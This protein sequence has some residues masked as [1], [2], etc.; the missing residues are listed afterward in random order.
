MKLFIRGDEPSPVLLGKLGG[1]CV[2]TRTRLELTTITREVEGHRIVGTTE[3]LPCLLLT[4]TKAEAS[5]EHWPEILVSSGEDLSKPVGS[6]KDY[7]ARCEGRSS[8]PDRSGWSAENFACEQKKL[9]DAAFMEGS[10]SDA[11]V[12][13]S[14]ALRHT[15]TNERL[16]SNR[17]AAYA[18][19]SKFQLALDDA[20]G[21]EEIDPTWSK[22]HFRKGQALQGLRRYEEAMAAFEAGRKL[23]PGSSE[24]ERELGRTKEALARRAARR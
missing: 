17:S 20:L 6:L 22:V 12:L 9:A 5:D 23:D 15:P 14:R 11:A 18:K 1:A 24:W 19:L 21:A 13:Y 8:S 3:T 16:L 4:L 7:V 10:F 2:P